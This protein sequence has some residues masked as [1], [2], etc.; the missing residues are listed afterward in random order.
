MVDMDLKRLLN[1]GQGH[2]CTN[3]FLI[4]DFL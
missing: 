1:K 4:Y 2:F 3:R